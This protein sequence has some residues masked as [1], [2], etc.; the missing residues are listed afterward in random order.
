MSIPTVADVLAVMA[1]MGIPCVQMHWDDPNDVPP[2]PYAL[3]MPESAHEQNTADGPTVEYRGYDIQLYTKRR[4]VAL[5]KA[6]TRALRGAG[7][8]TP[9]P[10]MARDPEGRVTISYFHTSLI[11][12]EH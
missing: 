1:S 11:E 7:I 4:D 12:Q 5:E 2:L 9:L 10:D 6:V 8:R 3:L